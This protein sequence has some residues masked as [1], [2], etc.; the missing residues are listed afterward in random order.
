[1]GLTI[2]DVLYAMI[3]VMLPLLLRFVWQYVAVRTTDSKYADALNS[4]FSAVD[5]VN[6]TFVDALKDKGCFDEEAQTY[7]LTMA[8]DAA[9]DLMGASTRRWLERAVTDLDSWLTMQIEARV[10]S[11]KVVA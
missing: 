5:Y 2:N 9:I 3:T 4:V 8:K 7:A 1:M 10:K 11:T 6:Q